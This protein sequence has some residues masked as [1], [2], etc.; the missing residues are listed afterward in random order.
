[1]GLLGKLIGAFGKPAPEPELKPQPEKPRFLDQTFRFVAIDVET[2]NNNQGSICQIGLALVD[3]AGEITTVDLLTDPEMEFF[4]FNVDLHGVSAEKVKGQPTFPEHLRQL[5]PFLERHPLIQHSSFDQRA[6]AA[7]CDRYNLPLLRSQWHDSVVIARR[8]WPEL[9]GNGGH[10]L[11]NL[12]THLGLEFEHHNAAEDARAAAEVVL[13]AEAHAGQSYID[14]S[15]PKTRAPRNYEISRAVEGNQ[16]GPLYGHIA[17]FTGKLTLS[18]N[19]AATY[20]AGAGIT[21][22][23]SVSKKITM[24]VVGDQDLD[25]LNGH[26]KSTKHRR[27]EEL[28][29]QGIDIRIMGETEFLKLIGK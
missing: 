18:R 26:T 8:A 9:K 3:E 12:K 1:M 27:A 29:E 13:K 4:S 17:C 5:R 20:A 15:A 19:D 16:N 10:G 7:A 28:I 25:T 22:K 11:G 6:F 23:S 14:L 2:A 21:V 24:L